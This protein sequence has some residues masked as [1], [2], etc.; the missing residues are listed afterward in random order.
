[1]NVDELYEQYKNQGTVDYSD[2]QHEGNGE[3][4]DIGPGHYDYPHQDFHTDE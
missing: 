3:H 4:L 1:M 2:Y